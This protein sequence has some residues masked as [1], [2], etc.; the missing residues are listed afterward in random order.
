M[1][2][3]FVAILFLLTLLL[4]GSYVYSQN[5]NYL[6]DSTYYV[7]E[8]QIG[9]GAGFTTGFGMSYRLVLNTVGIQ[10]NLFFFHRSH[11]VPNVNYSC[12]LTFLKYFKQT[13]RTF[14]YFYQANHFTNTFVR[15]NSQTLEDQT[16][17]NNHGIGLGVE[18]IMLENFTINFM[19]GVA[20]YVNANYMPV[21]PTIE[22]AYY[23][24][25]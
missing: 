8:Y 24:R 9:A 7:K 10:T 15:R 18:I 25:F 14:Y 19:A 12:G 4:G 16:Y 1:K 23:Y 5:D 17:S 6:Q 22:F 13:N 11:K 20:Y 21:A 2:R 3:E